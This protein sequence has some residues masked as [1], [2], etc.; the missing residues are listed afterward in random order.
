MKRNVIILSFSCIAF[1]LTAC[2]STPSK[3]NGVTGY[4]IESMSKENTTLSYT[5]AGR[6]NK[7]V[8][9]NKLQKAC[10]KALKENFDYKIQILS[11]TEIANPKNQSSNIQGIRLGQTRTSFGLSNTMNTN[12]NQNYATNQALENQPSTLQVVRYICSTR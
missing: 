12:S 5:M 9:I 6:N 10:Q 3:F 7:P 11:I 2:Q 1:A 8:D 4:E